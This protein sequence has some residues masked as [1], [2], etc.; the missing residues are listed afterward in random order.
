MPLL[1]VPFPPRY[2]EEDVT[3][4]VAFQ[5]NLEIR[6]CGNIVRFYCTEGNINKLY[7]HF[8]I[9]PLSPFLVSRTAQ[10]FCHLYFGI[11]TARVP[12]SAFVI[13]L[14]NEFGNLDQLP[15]L[16]DCPSAKWRRQQNLPCGIIIM[17][18]K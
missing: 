12:H 15:N 14:M 13:Y 16:S 4:E 11:K 1:E 5:Q 3:E 9:P 18:N 8:L 10:G 17:R 6:M 7:M 2:S